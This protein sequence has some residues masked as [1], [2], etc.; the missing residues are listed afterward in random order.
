VPVAALLALT[1]DAGKLLINNGIA[2]VIVG[3]DRERVDGA[4]RGLEPAA[5]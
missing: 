1:G 3:L 4:V 5:A 2:E